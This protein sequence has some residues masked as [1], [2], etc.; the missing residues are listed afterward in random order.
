MDLWQSLTTQVQAVI[1]NAASVNYVQNYDALRPTNVDGTRELLRFARTGMLKEFHL[2]S[3]TI[4]FGWTLKHELLETD[5]NDDMF[6]LEF[7]YAQS[8]WVAEQ[9]VFAAEK[10]GL[11]VRVYRPAFLSASTG[12]IASND[13]IIIRLLAFMINHGIAPDVGN[14]I[15][16]LPADIAA[17]NIAAIFQQR[18]IAERTFHV[19][20]DD[21]YNFTDVTRLITQEYGYPFDYYDISTFV[22]EMRRLCVR[23]DP[24]YPL[25]D[26]FSRFHPKITAMQCKRY[27]NSRYR[28]VRQL[29]GNDTGNPSL[30]ETVSYLMEHMLQQGVI[31]R[32]RISSGFD[33]PRQSPVAKS[34][35]PISVP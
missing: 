25:L 1:H 18:Q 8:K 32:M 4:I 16:F 34:L 22:A 21:Y 28:R 2:I 5:N 11:P 13:D 14:Q 7:G 26:F 3:S 30:K 31:P 29:A 35:G 27:N 33:L 12:G 19:T 20:V 24:V 23:D 17:T 9:L 10:Q 6:N 15:S